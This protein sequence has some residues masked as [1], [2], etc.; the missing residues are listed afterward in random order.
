MGSAKKIVG[1]M[2]YMARY[3]KVP[4]AT[5]STNAGGS[6]QSYVGDNPHENQSSKANTGTSIQAKKKKATGT[7]G[8]GVNIV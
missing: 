7:T 8:S 6:T 4:N 3:G 5:E 2:T 1:A